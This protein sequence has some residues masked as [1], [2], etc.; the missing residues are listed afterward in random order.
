MARFKAEMLREL[1]WFLFSSTYFSLKS[2]AVS[3]ALSFC[4]ITLALLVVAEM[5]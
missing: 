3:L 4:R 1:L 2:S 5:I